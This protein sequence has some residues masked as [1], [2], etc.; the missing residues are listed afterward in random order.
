M[1][2]GPRGAG[3]GTA[4]WTGTSRALRLTTAGVAAVLV[5]LVVAAV[6]VPGVEAWTRSWAGSATLAVVMLIGYGAAVGALG[7]ALAV[8]ARRPAGRRVPVVLAL[9]P[10]PFALVVGDPV[11]NGTV[12]VGLAT[13]AALVVGL[14]VAPTASD[15]Q[16][17]WLRRAAALGTP[18]WLLAGVGLLQL[19]LT[20]SPQ[21]VA[22]WLLGVQVAVVIAGVVTVPAILLVESVNALGGDGWIGRWLAPE[23]PRRAWAALAA[24]AAVTAVLVG[25]LVAQGIPLAGWWQALVVA[26]LVLLL[27]TLESLVPFADLGRGAG[28]AG[29][30]R[31][32]VTSAMGIIGLVFGGYLLLLAFQRPWTLVGLVL[33][34]A[35]AAFVPSPL[36]RRVRGRVAWV[37]VA[38][39]VAAWAWVAGPPIG[40]VPPG[41]LPGWSVPLVLLAL[42]VVILT[43][44]VL[45]LRARQWGFPVLA[46]AIAIGLASPL[47]TH[48]RAGA[49]PV[50]LLLVPALGLAVLVGR[51]SRRPLIEPGEVIRWSVVSLVGIDLAA[52]A[53]LATGIVQAAV[54]AVT[55]LTLGLAPLVLNRRGGPRV[56]AAGLVCAVFTAFVAMLGVGVRL[57]TGSPGLLEQLDQLN[58][59]LF[60]VIAFPVSAALSAA[61]AR[62]GHAHE[63]DAAG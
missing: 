32:T 25:I 52:A 33:V 8:H 12:G 27:L 62:P 47:L 15:P 18:A 46:L 48:E 22:G 59:A 13:W 54:L 58:S 60:W 39:V 53:T 44:V 42:V 19:A 43:Q 9:A 1:A 5:V 55:L 50:N 56:R 29:R 38:G 45:S 61:S 40:P 20:G 11:Q 49:V 6:V 37:G 28:L 14:L 2:D 34:F 17:S 63:A 21:A 3:G 4:A 10:F 7:G 30:L 26:V 36:D 23:T 35:A 57:P 24:K 31:L 16:A 41:D 51:W